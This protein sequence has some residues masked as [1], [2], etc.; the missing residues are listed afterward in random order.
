MEHFRL[1]LSASFNGSFSNFILFKNEK[2]GIFK[3]FKDAFQIDLELYYKFDGEY[4]EISEM[5]TLKDGNYRIVAVYHINSN[6]LDAN[7]LRKSL[8]MFMLFHKFLEEENIRH[9]F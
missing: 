5:E 9:N 2:E 7:R 3:G 6:R 4:L 8:K 1:S